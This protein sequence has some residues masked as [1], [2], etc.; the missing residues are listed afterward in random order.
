[1]GRGRGERLERGEEAGE[2]DLLPEE[3]KSFQVK[4]RRENRKNGREK[5]KEGEKR[6]EEAE[7][8]SKEEIQSFQI[9]KGVGDGEGAGVGLGGDG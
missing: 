3:I 7:G 4:E 9:E 6:W 5:G 2:D 8:Y 1:M